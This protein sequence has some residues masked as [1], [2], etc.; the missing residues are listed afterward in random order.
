MRDLVA[1]GRREAAH[2]A[3]AFPQVSRRVGGYL[4]DAL[5]A[6]P[7]PVNL[8]ALLCGSE[9]TLA[10]SRLIELKLSPLPK[11]R[12][13]GICHF[14]TF[15]KA[16]EAAQHIVKLGPV[17]VEVVDN[18]LIELALD[19]AMFRPVMEAFV[20]GK[21]DALLLVEFAQTDQTEN[22]RRLDR[23]DQLMGDLGHPRSV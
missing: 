1:L 17:A 11:N 12:A 3:Q 16:M 21:P 13:L 15:R 23:L 7:G 19:I 22:V 14:T 18:T 20:R 10:V 8:A 2:I 4:I 9:G 6:S 5:V